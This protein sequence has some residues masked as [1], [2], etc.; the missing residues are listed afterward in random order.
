MS[1]GIFSLDNFKKQ[2]VMPSI[3][4]SHMQGNIQE[5]ISEWENIVLN[6]YI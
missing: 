6:T 1:T 4:D 2:L 3:S 5:N